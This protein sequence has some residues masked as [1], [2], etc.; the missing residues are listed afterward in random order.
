[1]DVFMTLFRYSDISC[2]ATHSLKHQYLPLLTE[3]R[4]QQMFLDSHTIPSQKPWSLNKIC[5]V[6]KVL[7]I[8]RPILYFAVGEEWFKLGQF[9]LNGI[10]Y[11]EIKETGIQSS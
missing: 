6:L 10:H 2:H 7:P 5:K 1:M 4:G 3:D 9:L 8:P 11:D